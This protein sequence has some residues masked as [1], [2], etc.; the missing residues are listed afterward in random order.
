VHAYV[1]VTVMY[2]S[3]YKL[4]LLC[5]HICFDESFRC[6]T[7]VLKH[8]NL[9]SAEII[10]T[11]PKVLHHNTYINVQNITLYAC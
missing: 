8:D 3:L 11:L 5:S 1:F 6:R 7:T 4:Y 2:H 9:V 10:I